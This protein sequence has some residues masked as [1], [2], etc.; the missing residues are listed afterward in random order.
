M[1]LINPVATI[2][3]AIFNL[4]YIFT[5]LFSFFASYGNLGSGSSHWDNVLTVKDL[6]DFLTVIDCRYLMALITCLIPNS[7]N[8]Q[9]STISQILP[10]L[11][12]QLCLVITSDH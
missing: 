11:W 9:N 1:R 4:F 6:F 12:M 2:S 10:H 8:L 5:D 7:C 3:A